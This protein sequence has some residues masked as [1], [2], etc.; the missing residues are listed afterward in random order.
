MYSLSNVWFIVLSC[1]CYH[2]G[3][4]SGVVSCYLPVCLCGEDA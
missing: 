1:I 4:I 3:I 2:G